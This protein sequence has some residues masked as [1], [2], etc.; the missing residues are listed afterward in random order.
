[1]RP[2]TNI[3]CL[4]VLVLILT[5]AIN[6]PVNDY[7]GVKPKLVATS[8]CD[9]SLWQHVYA[10][11]PRKFSKPQDR[12][13]VI[14]P[15]VTITGTLIHAKTEADGDFHITVDLDPQYKSML[16]AKNTSG[17]HGYLVVE[18]VCA[19]PVTQADTIKEHACDNFSQKIYNKGMDGKHVTISGAYVTDMEHGWSEVHPVSSITVIP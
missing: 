13:K 4:T 5:Y 15:C 14:T 3:A 8:P 18:P 6:T 17:Q 7:A 19:N 2:L 10:G 1:M 16:N 12:L 11:D 9:A